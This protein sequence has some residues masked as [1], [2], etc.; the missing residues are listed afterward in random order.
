MKIQLLLIV[1]L[2]TCLGCSTHESRTSDRDQESVRVTR[3]NQVEALLLSNV[4]TRNFSS[5]TVKDTFKIKLTGK[6]ITE[7][8]VEF[9]IKTNDGL[10]IHYST[11]PASY[12]IGYA[13][14]ENAS[15]HE[16]AEYI[17]TRIAQFFDTENFQ[18][19]AISAGETFDADYSEK[20]VWDDIKSDTTAVAF[21]YLVG[22]EAYVRIAYS[23]KL[24]RV[25][26]IFGCC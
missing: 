5:P 23:K 11:F 24:R 13:L 4:V 18:Q 1:G 8:K 7:G 26:T 14:D 21:G 22:E 12:L 25:V 9:E 16:Q 6:T 19:P 2:F 3:M 17:K 20:P 15:E 10:V